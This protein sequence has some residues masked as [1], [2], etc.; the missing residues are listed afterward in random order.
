[1]SIADDKALST[2]MRNYIG[3]GVIEILEKYSPDDKIFQYVKKL[4]K[5]TYIPEYDL[6]V[7][8]DMK[9]D[10]RIVLKHMK[11][12]CEY[13]EK[14]KALGLRVRAIHQKLA[15]MK[16]YSIEAKK[17]MAKVKIIEDIL[18]RACTYLS[19]YAVFLDNSW[20]FSLKINLCFIS[21]MVVS[22]RKE[23]K[24]E[25]VIL[26]MKTLLLDVNATEL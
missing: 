11:T 24:V 7:E 9:K 26:R 14:M 23:R 1:M 8:S 18:T 13:Y 3:H 19:R 2:N 20:K 4:Q 22:K 25:T 16:H 6:E 12:S 15:D 17:M 5:L 21:V 10:L